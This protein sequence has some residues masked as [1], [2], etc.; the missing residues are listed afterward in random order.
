MIVSGG[1]GTTVGPVGVSDV[2]VP[3]HRAIAR[4]AHRD[5]DRPAVVEE[6][7]GSCTYRE[8]ACW[9]GELADRLREAGVGPGSAVA[10]RLPRSARLVA[11]LLAVFE[12]GGAAV[13]LDPRTPAERL[14]AIET[15]AGCAAV[16]VPAEES[17]Q[18]G[19]LPAIAVPARPDAIRG[20][21]PVPAVTGPDD[22]LDRVAC[23]FYTSG[24]TGRPKGVQVTHRNLG[25]FAADPRWDGP[26]HRVTALVSALGFDALSHDLWLSLTRGG[27]VVV[28]AEDRVDAHRLA[29]LVAAH[30]VTG[31]FL[32]TAWFNQIAV[33]EPQAL[34]GLH[35]VLTG[36]EAADAQAFARVRAACPQL[37]LG[38][39]YGP[40][41][42]TTFTTHHPLPPGRPVPAGRVPIGTGLDGVTVR[43]LGPDLDEVA[44]G[45]PGEVYVAGEQVARGYLGRPGLTAERFVPDPYGPPGARMYRTGDLAV[46][47]S[48]GALEYLAR[49]D[50]QVKIRGHRVEPGEARAALAA[51]PGVAQAVVVAR[52]GRLVGYAVPERDRPGLTGEALRA[53]LS[54]LLPEYL[55]PAAVLLL[56]D[57]P[58]TVNGKVDRAA[59]PAPVAAR[60]GAGVPRTPAERAL[61][62]AFAEVL[63]LPA[64]ATED[65]F[66]AL[67]GDSITAMRLVSRV[68]REN[69]AISSQDV[70]RLRTP[71]ALA[72]AAQAAAP[73][74]DLW[75]RSATGRLGLPPIAL[76][77]RE[78][79]EGV[80]EFVQS[81]LVETPRGL[82]RGAL[83][84]ALQTVL[85][86]HDAL[87]TRLPEPSPQA[88]WQP[89]VLAPG[90]VDAAGLLDVVDVR[91]SA[92]APSARTVQEAVERA[93]RSLDLPAGRLLRAV[94]WDAGPERPG[95][96]LLAVHHLVVDGVSWQVLVQDLAR[97][98]EDP[99]ALGSWGSATPYR[100][101][102]QEHNARADSAEV[103]AT[104]PH[105]QAA[106]VPAT[107]PW[108]ARGPLDPEVDVIATSRT[109]ESV[110]PPEVGRALLTTAPAHFGATPQE[111]LLTALTVA[112]ARCGRSRTLV[113]DTE[114][115]G[116]TAAAAG[117]VLDVSATVG[118]FTCMFPVRLQCPAAAARRATDP[119]DEATALTEA[120]H[121]VR[122]RWQQVPQDRASYGLLRHLHPQAATLLSRAPG[123]PVLFNY[124][125]R[126]AVPGRDP[127]PYAAE[128]PV[129]GIHR[130]G[131]QPLSHPL[132]INA[133][134][135]ERTGEPR[136]TALWRWSA[137]LVDDRDAAELAAQWADVLTTL[138]RTAQAGVHTRVPAQREGEQWPCSPLQEGLLYH[139][140]RGE[141]TADPY[142]VQTVLDLEGP[143]D[144]PALRTALSALTAQHPALRARFRWDCHGRA[145]QTVPDTVDVPVREVDL[146]GLPETDREP[147]ADVETRR[148]RHEP[149]DLA[150]APLLRAVVLRLDERRSRLLL[151]YHHILMDGW[152][153]QVA[154]ADLAD[155]YGQAASGTV[156]TPAAR[157]SALAYLRHVA[158]QDTALAAKTWRTLLDG[159]TEPTL[160]TSP[161]REHHGRPHTVLLE[162][163]AEHTTALR[164]RARE[165][166]LSLNTL[167]LGAWALVLAQ[168]TGRTDVVF[169]TVVADRPPHLPGIES[170]VGLM[171][172]AV[173]VRADTTAA[174]DRAGLLTALQDQRTDMMPHQQLGLAE[175]IRAA[176][177][178]ELFD[179]VVVLETYTDAFATAWGTDLRVTSSRVEN[180]THYALCLLVSPGDRIT[181]RVQYQPGRL[182]EDGA[183][184][185]GERFLAALEALTSD[186]SVPAT[187]PLASATT[188]RPAAPRPRRLSIPTPVLD[189]FAAQVQA[190]PGHPA[191]VDGAGAL[192]YRGLDAASDRLARDLAVRGIG[193][194]DV[195]A[196][197][198][199]RGRDAVAAMLAVL[200]AGAAYL[201]LDPRHPAARV[202]ALAAEGRPALLLQHA[203]FDQAL[204][205][206]PPGLPRM[207]L[208]PHQVSPVP[209]P[210]TDRVRPDRLPGHPAYVVHT[211][212]TQGVPKAV[213]MPG[214]ALDRL[215][216]WHAQR[217]PAESGAVTAQFTSMAFD[218]AT[219]EV[220][221]ALCTGRTLAVPDAD[222]RADAAAWTAWLRAH[223]VT[224]LFAPTPVL[225]ALCEF[226]DG[227]REPLPD[228]RHLVQAGEALVVGPQ[229]RELCAAGG[230]R[231]HNHYGPAE[232]HVV[233]AGEIGG[234]P[235]DWPARPGIGSPV[236]GS[237]VMLLDSGLSPVPDGLTGELYLAGDQLARGYLGRPALTAARFVADPWGPPGSRMYRTGDLARRLPDGTLEFTGRNDDQVKIRGHRIEP[238]EVR[239]ALAALPGVVQAA[240]VAG[241]DG[242]GG[243]ELT[244]YAVGSPHTGAPLDGVT[245]REQLA[246]VLP[247]FMLPGRIMVLDRMPLTVNGKVDHRALP[248][249]RREPA[250]LREPRTP[251]ERVVTEAFADVLGLERVG[252]DDDFFHL[253][254]HSLL[255]ARLLQRLRERLNPAAT[256][257]QVMQRATPATMAATLAPAADA[258]APA[259][260]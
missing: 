158:D 146:T 196:L 9:A 121:A 151:S 4:V 208:E 209:L 71:G 16:I 183:R 177:L 1:V 233:T 127:W 22:E 19:D 98:A 24:S 145:V 154:L 234:K 85:D 189:R 221:T 226:A 138:A 30:G 219:Q 129:L 67:G 131:R 63:G 235:A 60:S 135:D 191:V 155:L 166:A 126:Y 14:A 139:A 125:G 72:T 203:E 157:S 18:P 117:P 176:G 70:F 239:A 250:L 75:H 82:E 142:H 12:A 216:D 76:W 74:A 87:R 180:G 201:W 99:Q 34:R 236:P 232:T 17:A 215:V 246:R 168:L 186:L 230:K 205:L 249:P 159:V 61:C 171:N 49:D 132:E 245:L 69:V 25:R 11:S 6:Q 213:V 178:R 47:G 136:L 182:T 251:A 247:D 141:D 39:V 108:P 207:R 94:W 110:L 83:V 112:A 31:V 36:G 29:A 248:A 123:R 130:A 86:R 156:P 103:L 64:A 42:C 252:V 223:R 257:A 244:G 66:F 111:L 37:V 84:T 59:L 167:V 97:A 133:V 3:V 190:S 53:Q 92:H 210:A 57:I 160:L 68:R 192:D 225:A 124:L 48:G 65:D 78:Q 46:R 134:V 150:V 106:S 107:T 118:W 175:I 212:G 259:D 243:K 88:V 169:G 162:L 211:S 165:R 214:A 222:T 218:V 50:D 181:V 253:G 116:R 120:V 55:V 33:D 115:H 114:G 240:V 20:A 241:P 45:E 202:A 144:A 254:G 255:A 152:S 40:T 2:L 184:Q 56:H 7:G 237:R 32:T 185:I 93:M 27:T 44:A 228:L 200:K 148:D 77:L 5:P 10:L 224:E 137:R 21:S 143:V 58:L 187:H 173:P 28:P 128:A 140:H 256:L 62:A 102:V 41:E 79:G 26:G 23:V 231:L 174:G 91:V 220:L 52:D 54:R 242:R 90:E 204:A 119:G 260:A 195:V 104:L 109:M 89:E 198:L 15:D 179:T 163:A 197:C 43:L 153:M 147:A 238:D 8:V 206:I 105:W 100:Q 122:E 172:N 80:D 161:G 95:R 96:L 149:F 217:F 38:H 229:L 73:A 113:L 194:E 51:L 188:T 35:T 170:M 13:V 193:A 199:R 164:A 81:V 101:W 227:Q 258:A